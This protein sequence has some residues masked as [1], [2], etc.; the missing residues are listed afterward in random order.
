MKAIQ[1]TIV[2]SVGVLVLSSC[3]TMRGNV[4]KPRKPQSRNSSSKTLEL[5]REI[6]RQ[7]SI[8]EELRERNLV[9]ERRVHQGGTAPA[10]TPVPVPFQPS[11][12][13]G[14]AQKMGEPVR[15]AAPTPAPNAPV[16]TQKGDRLLYSKVLETYRR[17]DASEMKKAVELLI[18]TYPDSVFADNSLYLAGM[19][20]VEKGN[21]TDGLE[22]MTRL[23][24]DYPQGNKAVAALFAKGMIEKRMKRPEE[25]RKNLV[26]L[27]K[28]YPGSPEANR[29]QL[30]LKALGVTPN[31]REM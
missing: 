3:A 2:A 10:E 14:F 24:K 1:R 25:A 12:A 13:S 28:L 27:K 15:E 20:H 23:L 30:E 18:K 26:L 4:E 21:F 6:R 29:V 19:L 7:Q 5:Q 17:H 31:K 9:L 22:C 16:E 11:A 8:I